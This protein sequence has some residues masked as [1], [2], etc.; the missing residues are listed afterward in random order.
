[1]R[2]ERQFLRLGEYLVSRACRRLPGEMRRER[3]REWAAELPA[4]LGDPDIRLAPHRVARM[5]RY[6]AD[7][8]RG[9]AALSP[10]RARRVL[11]RMSRWNRIIAI[12][13][14]LGIVADI[15]SAV[16]A[17]GNWV[18]YL[19]LALSLFAPLVM[20]LSIR[21]PAAHPSPANSPVTGSAGRA[22]SAEQ[23]ISMARDTTGRFFRHKAWFPGYQVADVD[24]FIARIEAT[25]SGGL[26]PEQAVTS[27]DVQAVKFHTTRHG[28][29]DEMVVDQALDHYADGLDRSMPPPP[30]LDAGH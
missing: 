27:A 22:V 24:E 30:A 18:P 8:I 3:Y 25:L 2:G 13:L 11:A 29:Y 23:A 17:P 14:V 15:W 7:M 26:R 21:S 1:M 19:F 5:L 20:A 4:I 12:F 10:G 9:T 16:R 6:A 28:G